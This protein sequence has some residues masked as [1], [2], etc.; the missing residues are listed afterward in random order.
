MRD[1]KTVRD[2]REMFLAVH[3][4]DDECYVTLHYPRPLDGDAY[5]ELT[6]EAARELAAH[7]L[8]CADEVDPPPPDE[9]KGQFDH[10]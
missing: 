7:L 10:P 4:D 5:S 8:A 6:A 1:A 2:R 3:S 9:Q